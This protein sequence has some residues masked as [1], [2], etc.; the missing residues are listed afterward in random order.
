MC[1]SDFENGGNANQFAKDLKKNIGNLKEKI[2][3]QNNSN[4]EDELQENERKL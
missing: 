1:F 3:Q 4:T 2:V